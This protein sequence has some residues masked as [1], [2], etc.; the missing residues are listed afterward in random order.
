MGWEVPMEMEIEEEL[1]EAELAQWGHDKA[2]HDTMAWAG[3]VCGRQLLHGH[4]SHVQPEVRCVPERWD[5]S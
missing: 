4:L 3:R 2:A 1:R 5:G